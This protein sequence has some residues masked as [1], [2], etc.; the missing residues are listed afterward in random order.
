MG[1]LVTQV[2]YPGV[3]IEEVPSGV[4][5][6]TSV[7]T[8]ITAFLGRANEGPINKAV[9]ILSLSEFEKI[10]GPAHPDSELSTSV[11]LFFQNGGTDC[12]VIR[13]VGLNSDGTITGQKASIVLKNEARTTNVFEFSAKEIGTW[14]NE[15]ALEIDYNTAQPEDTFN[16]RIYRL[17]N[18]VTVKDREEFVSCSADGDS[19]KFVGKVISQNSKLVDCKILDTAASALL[20]AGYSE[21][22]KPYAAEADLVADLVRLTSTEK[23][24]KFQIS[25]DGSAPSEVDLEGFSSE[26]PTANTEKLKVR[27]NHALPPTLANSV[28]VEFVD[29]PIADATAGK[30]LR[31]SSNTP[32]KK[33]VTIQPSSAN[34]LTRELMLG[35]EQG[36]IERSRYSSIRPSPTGMFLAFDQINALASKDQTA[37]STITLDGHT[38]DLGTRLQTVTPPG[39]WFQSAVGNKT[40][41]VREKLK[42]IASAINDDGNGWVA[43]VAG[44]RLLVR[45]KTGPAYSTSPSIST[46]EVPPTGAGSVSSFFKT[47]TKLDLLGMGTSDFVADAKVGID[48]AAPNFASYVG[49]QDAHSGFYALDLVDIFNLMVLPRDKRLTE[50]VYQG[51]WAPA[52]TYC[53]EHRAFLIVEPTESWI[54]YK[55]VLDQ[56]STFRNGLEKKNAAVYFPRLVV[57]ENGLLRTVGPGGAIAGLYSRTDSSGGGGVWKAPAG[58]SADIQA[59]SD[60]DII[61]T[62]AENGTLN[63]EGVNCLR[64]FASGIVSW[65]ARTIDGADDFSSEWKYIPI[66]RLTLMIEESLFRGTKW[67]VFEPN[68]EPLW[69]RIRLNVRAY[70]MGLFRQGAFQGGSPDKA[71]FVKCDAETTPQADRNLG[72]VNILVGF[73]PLKPAEFVIIKIQ[74]MV[75]EL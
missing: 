31:F 22:R 19:P 35:T 43:S 26:T 61:L 18:N 10:F 75:G 69:A 15:L 56:K 21:S 58:T 45:K 57:R 29:N 39:K 48:G 72:I 65:G 14:G 66:R 5:T 53:S 47:N 50:D 6:I 12:Y 41:G 74:Q 54:D 9:R 32:N 3:Y 46:N 51:L 73:A 2:T 11:K 33:S 38:I 62:D 40:D 30:V 8:S 42:I 52:S 49:K 68:D 71:F 70:M 59:I 64:R 44:S 13:L 7:A 60:L 63:K 20:D 17:A 25:V 28:T 27:I 1:L 34:D 16:V 55:T 37:F 23:K 36:G 67:V 24:S 4:H